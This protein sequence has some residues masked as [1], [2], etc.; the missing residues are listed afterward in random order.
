VTICAAARSKT[1]EL[2]RHNNL[3]EPGDTFDMRNKILYGAIA[4]GLTA[5]IYAFTAQTG[6]AQAAG[7]KNLKV[8]PKDT[9]KK[10]IKKAMKGISDALGVEC[11]YCHDLDDMAKDTEHKESAR[12][13]MKMVNTINKDSFKGKP[14]VRC[15][16]CHNGK[17]KPK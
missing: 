2:L 10:Q 15:V 1:S 6:A 14:R 11:D 17:K 9:S 8:F 13:M 16:T 5:L 12:A 4:A 7:P 3:S